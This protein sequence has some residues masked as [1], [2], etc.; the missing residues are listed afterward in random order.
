MSVITALSNIK[1]RNIPSVG[2]LCSVRMEEGGFFRSFPRPLV[3]LPSHPPSLFYC[4]WWHSCGITL[5]RFLSLE[6]E[7]LLNFPLASAFSYRLIFPLFS[8]ST[9]ALVFRG[10]PGGSAGHSSNSRIDSQPAYLH[11]HWLNQSQLYLQSSSS[12]ALFCVLSP[13]P[14]TTASCA[15]SVG[16]LF[17]SSYLDFEQI[18]SHGPAFFLTI[19]PAPWKLTQDRS[20]WGRRIMGYVGTPPKGPNGG[21]L[22]FPGGALVTVPS[23]PRFSWCSY[24]FAWEQAHS[25]PAK[26]SHSFWIKGGFAVFSLSQDS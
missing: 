23:V 7:A 22:L 20:V 21:L 2:V 6:A 9:L 11:W 4:T 12:L 24:L 5:P 10:A 13:C 15:K 3:V 26:H 18:L 17:F 8:L 14:H 16:L 25:P 1:G 19:V